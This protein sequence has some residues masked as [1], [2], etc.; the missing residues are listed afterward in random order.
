VCVSVDEAH[1]TLRVSVRDEVWA[2]PVPA[3]VQALTALND[4][5]EAA[6]GTMSAE[7]PVRGATTVL[8]SPR[9]A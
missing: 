1:T 6:G 4:R 9:I 8:V 7:S 3:G 5:T 2:A